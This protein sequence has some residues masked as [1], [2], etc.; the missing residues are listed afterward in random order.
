M[1]TRQQVRSKHDWSDEK[2]RE[3]LKAG[4]DYKKEIELIKRIEKRI[5]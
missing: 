5:S 1:R 3:Y 2:E 4:D